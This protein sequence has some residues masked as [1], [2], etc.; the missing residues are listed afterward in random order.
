MK[1]KEAPR[2]P[3]PIVDRRRRRALV[4]RGTDDG[5]VMPIDRAAGAPTDR[6]LCERC[7]AVY[8]RKIWRR[9]KAG[10]LRPA[11]RLAWGVCPACVQVEV[12]QYFGRVL[13]RGLR[14]PGA[15][16][17]VVRRI[18]N[19]GRRAALRQPERR[20]VSIDR[21][22][23]GIEVLTTSQK[24]AHRI[25]RSL[26]AAFGG[27]VTYAWSDRDGE[28]FAA[29]TWEQPPAAPG[30]KPARPAAPS[31]AGA[32]VPRFE[33]RCRAVDVDPAWEAI[34][35]RQVEAWMPRH[36]DLAL[37]R[38]TLTG[39]RHH[40]HG[41]ETV[42]VHA[43]LAGRTLHAAKRADTLEA[44]LRGALDAIGREMGVPRRRTRP[45][46]SRRL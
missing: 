6:T 13:I 23:E 4:R 8:R 26:Y 27:R 9:K 11:G 17:E 40:R 18:E 41:G 1:P 15:A 22:G 42:S 25:A 36:P 28:L 39:G 37:L 29:W 10:D 34:V 32:I 38:V 31:A 2:I 33:I 5:Q 12:G 45:V 19:V 7:G 16:R 43:A 20:I 21:L 3:P 14:D 35:H 30:R 46:S 24:L 44:A